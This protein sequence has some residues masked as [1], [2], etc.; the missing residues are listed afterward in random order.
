MK[1]WVGTSVPKIRAVDLVTGKAL[2]SDDIQLGDAV[3]LGVFRSEKSHA[4]IM[5]VDAKRAI[6]KPG[7]IG[8]L[9]AADVP[10]RNLHGLSLPDQP[11]LAEDRVRFVGEAIVL[12]AAENREAL[13][14]GIEAIEVKF[15][16]LPGV[17]R[18]EDALKHDAPR[19]HEKGNVLFK[20][21]IKKGDVEKGFSKSSIIVERTYRTQLVE[22][23][24]L[25]P[26]AGLGYIDKDGVFVI[27]CST[28]NPHDDQKQ[29]AEILGVKQEQ[30]RIIQASTGGGFGS[31]LDLTVQGYIGLAL[32]HLKRPARL[33]YSREE[34]YLATPKRHP[35]MI[36]M[37]TGA[38]SDGRLQ[39][40]RVKALLDTGAYA[41]FGIAV[42]VRSAVHATG[43]YEVENV[44][45]ECLAVYTNNP[46]AGAMRGFGVP[47]IAFAHESQMDIL[48]GELGIDPLAIRRLNLVKPGSATATRQKLGPGVG[49]SAALDVIEPHYREAKSHWK[50]GRIPESKTRGVGLG[51]MWYGI[52]TT[53]IKN[54]STAKV[55][56]NPDGKVTLYTG[57]A[58]IGQGSTTVLTQIA[59]EILGLAPED[60]NLVVADTK[61]TPVAGYTS[62]SRQTYISGNAVKHAAERLADALI[63]EA[64]EV[65]NVPR[66]Q[67]GLREGF[68]E[69]IYQDVPK[70]ISLRDLAR[71]LYQKNLPHVWQ[72]YYD[73]DTTPLDP[74]TGAGAPYAA[75]SFAC[76]LALVEVDTET[77][78]VSVSRIVAA[79]DV[80]KAINPQNVEGQ[81]QGGVAMGVGFAVMEQYIPGKTVSMGDCCLPTSLDVPSIQPFIVEVHEPSGPFGAKGVGEPALI[82]TTPAILNAIADALGD[83][84]YT[85]PANAERVWKACHK[86]IRPKGEMSDTLRDH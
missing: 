48:A 4:R 42:A 69:D 65:L 62:A 31:K 40:V 30:V 79:H 75:Y 76:Q 26:D 1:R 82:P 32:Y 53:G 7:V 19:I 45:A 83:R 49:I 21:A 59:C 39:A 74:D 16:D 38:T 37:K 33:V 77:G 9:T 24:Y 78:E 56:I 27:Y 54:P 3:I 64:I 17:H 25:E 46:I 72:G 36:E 63:T 23:N 12:V 85:L 8:V 22:H 34:T 60:M 81:I 84:I 44:E 11:L 41:S 14:K 5:S 73:P 68:V 13:K 86:R 61:L 70:K 20:R 67:L 80:G 66:E 58:D 43:P 35:F 6:E 50:E 2:F 10:G 15:E 28:Q 52:G 57:A 18:I 71:G 29:V 55:E 51:T 47:Q